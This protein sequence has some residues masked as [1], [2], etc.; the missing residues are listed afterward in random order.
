[1]ADSRV[2]WVEGNR[3]RVLGVRSLGTGVSVVE[4]FPGA[5]AGRPVPGGLLG[6]RMQPHVGEPGHSSPGS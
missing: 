6:C 5:L 2:G 4:L 1:M 3:W